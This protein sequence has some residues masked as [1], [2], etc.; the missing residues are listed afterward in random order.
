M[1]ISRMDIMKTQ[2]VSQLKH[3]ENQRSQ[4]AQAQIGKSFQTS[5]QQDMK[6]PTQASKSDTKE[7]RYDAKEKGNN[8]YK[9]PSNKKN[10]NKEEKGKSNQKP[11]GGID[12]LI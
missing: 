6:K 4:Q 11:T 9:E 5:I 7:Y 2:E 12:I 10:H 1:S 3:I 8:Q